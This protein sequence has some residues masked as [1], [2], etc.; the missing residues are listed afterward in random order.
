MGRMCDGGRE[1]VRDGHGTGH[2][3]F[4]GWG[5]AASW[6]AHHSWGIPEKTRRESDAKLSHQSTT[7]SELRHLFLMEPNTLIAPN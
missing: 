7:E 2:D 4:N 1:G 5:E 6:Q 3:A